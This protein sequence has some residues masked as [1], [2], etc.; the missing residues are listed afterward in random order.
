[1]AVPK[2]DS[3]RSS[4]EIK[5][6]RVEEGGSVQLTLRSTECRLAVLRAVPG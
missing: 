3:W 2:G 1:M 4:Q 6:C 5:G